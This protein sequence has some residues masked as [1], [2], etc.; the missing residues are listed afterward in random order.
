M[1][2]RSYTAEFKEQAARQVIQGGR[3]FREVAEDLGVDQSSLRHWVRMARAAGVTPPP[4]LAAQDPAK[5]VRELEAE[6]RQLRMEREILKKAAAFFAKESTG[7]G[8][9]P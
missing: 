4:A 6:V 5:R 3:S 7:E 8:G 9:R 1:G 2:R